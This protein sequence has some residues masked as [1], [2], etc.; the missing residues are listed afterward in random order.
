[1]ILSSVR[2][3]VRRSGR[4]ARTAISG[5]DRDQAERSLVCHLQSLHVLRAPTVGVFVAHDGEPDLVP[6]INWL[7]DND[8]A[9]ALPVLADDPT[10]FS[11]RFLP[12]H[13]GDTLRAGRYDIPVPP[14][15]PR[16][17]PETLLVSFTGFD[18]TGNRIGRGGGFYDR[19][20]ATANSAVVGV[21]FESQRFDQVPVENHDQRLPIVVTDRGVRY[22][23]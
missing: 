22:I 17:V 11:M 14:A 1:M 5:R 8:R 6:L 21:G 16:V 15:R 7:W 23:P 19:Y 10:D 13:R 20:L 2:S 18:A 4:A 3:E 9:V 12:W